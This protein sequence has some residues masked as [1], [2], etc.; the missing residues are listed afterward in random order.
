MVDL[1]DTKCRVGVL[2]ADDRGD[3][4]VNDNEYL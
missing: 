2:T 1:F 4:V 3:V